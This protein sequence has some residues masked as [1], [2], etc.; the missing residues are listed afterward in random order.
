MPITLPLFEAMDGDL[1]SPRILLRPLTSFLSTV[2]V[3]AAV[4]SLAPSVDC[5]FAKG[6]VWIPNKNSAYLVERKERN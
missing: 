2:A 6:F 4:V 3:A 1:R 5:Y